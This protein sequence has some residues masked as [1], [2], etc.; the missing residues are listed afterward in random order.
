[1]SVGGRVAFGDYARER[2]SALLRAAQAI[3]GNRADAEDL[4]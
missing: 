1:M 2:S 4:V 3:T